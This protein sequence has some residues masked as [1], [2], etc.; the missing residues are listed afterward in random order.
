ME[1]VSGGDADDE[2]ASSQES[3]REVREKERVLAAVVICF[4]P[5]LGPARRW[6]GGGRGDAV[7]E[8]AFGGTVGA[9][10]V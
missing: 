4:G 3:A 5:E 7:S 9:K 1:A 6:V 8:V 10:E 2:D